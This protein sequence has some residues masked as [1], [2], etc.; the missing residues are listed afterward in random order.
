MHFSPFFEI[1]PLKASCIIT[2]FFSRHYPHI[3]RRC[4]IRTFFFIRNISLVFL[5]EIKRGVY[6]WIIYS[7]AY[8][9]F[10]IYVKFF[11]LTFSLRK[12]WTEMHFVAVSLAFKLRTDWLKV[13]TLYQKNR[14]S[15]QQLLFHIEKTIV[16]RFSG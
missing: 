10:I 5:F 15:Q 1:I 7:R 11:A 8:F 2:M 9:N 13:S 12:I 6:T 3:I 4:V 14:Y 16:Y